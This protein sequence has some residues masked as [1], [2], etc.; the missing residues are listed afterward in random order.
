MAQIRV[1]DTVYNLLKDAADKDYR[2]IG[3]EIEYL[4]RNRFELSEIQ[5]ALKNKSQNP[6]NGSGS[7][8]NNQRPNGERLVATGDKAMPVRESLPDELEEAVQ[9]AMTA[10][11]NMIPE[12]AKMV[13]DKRCIDEGWS[14]EQYKYEY[15]KYI[16][17]QQDIY[18]NA[19]A[20]LKEHNVSIGI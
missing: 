14:D 20:I 17:E 7:Q 10:K 3:G 8:A 9:M 1:D 11:K 18:D 19:T 15:D 12:N 6:E 16:S 2:T 13:C 4:L 5:A